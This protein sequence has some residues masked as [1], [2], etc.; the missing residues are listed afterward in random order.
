MP[1][2]IADLRT[3]VASLEV[4]KITNLQSLKETS[5]KWWNIRRIQPFFPCMEQLFKL[6]TIRTPYQYGLK[7][8]NTIQTIS[9]IESVYTN[10]V[11]VQIHRKTTMLLPAY[12][13]MRGDF[14]TSGLPCDKNN[15][16]EE[17]DRLHSYH[18][19][20]YVGALANTVLSE[21]GC[22]HFP[23][24]YGTFT[25]IAS[26][27]VI[28]ISDDYED[29]AERP[30]FLQNLGH[31]FDLKL[32]TIPPPQTQE[33]LQL[34]EDIELDAEVLEPIG[35]IDGVPAPIEEDDEELSVEDD[36]IDEEEADSI[37]TGYV[38]GVRT[39][40][41]DGNNYEDG[42]GF[43]NDDEEVFAEAIFHD[44]PV[45]T[46]VMQKC[47]DTMYTLFK[48]N[49]EA[50]KRIAWIAQVVFALAFAQRNFGL[51]HNDL[52][53]NNVMYV[54]T[55]KEHLYYNVGGK[56]YKVPT[57][58][59]IMKIIDFDRATY[60]VKLTGMRD[61]RFF[62]SDHFDTY[63]EAG[64]QYNVE[65]FYNPKFPEIKPNASFDLVRLATS[66][67]WDCF[68]EGPLCEKY[69]SDPL[70]NIIMTW[71]TL[72]DGSS[73]LFRNLAEKDD[74]RR[75][76]SFHLYK[77]IARYCRGT[78]VPKVQIEKMAGPYLTTEKVPIGESCLFIEV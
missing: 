9:G 44:V 27:H 11:E 59:Y 12:R 26:K 6:E 64:G 73:I 72:P 45:Q 43:S 17:H 41:T 53:V 34:G 10:G 24:V 63:E 61:A 36:D 7:T 30:W 77:A 29:L 39:C 33:P 16:T 49:I 42:Y 32:K 52:H 35:S 8:K 25:G 78:A 19:A 66:M 67:F 47:E 46:T 50:H 57:Y 60:S 18:N 22:V 37:S 76:A 55:N 71:T 58:G 31:F 70:F 20:A 5:E 68:P 23:E 62:M 4:N 3:S 15:S 56:Q 65:P 14:G 69:K 38:F 40:S 13:I 74:H 75:F 21:S 2:P 54:S 28:D 51:V 1:K 48:K